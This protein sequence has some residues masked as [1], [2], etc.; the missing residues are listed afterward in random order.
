MS[1]VLQPEWRKMCVTRSRQ[2][3][4]GQLRFSIR[5]SIPES[6]ATTFE[7]NHNDVSPTGCFTSFFIMKKKR[8]F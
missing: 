6:V 5:F 8:D 2:L 1:N 4:K 7:R 3:L